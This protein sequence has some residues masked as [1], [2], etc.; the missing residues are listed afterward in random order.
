MDSGVPRGPAMYDGFADM[1]E[2]HAAGSPYNAY[3]DRPAVFDLCGD[4]R[5]RRVLDAG[6]GPGL[7]GEQLIA[8]GA[9]YEGFDVSADMVRVARRRLGE[10]VPLRTHDLERPLS[11]VPDASV[12]LVVCALVVHYLEDRVGALRE[13]R[14]VLAPG[15][16]AVLSTSHPTADWLLDGD[17][18][19][20][21]RH[22]ED[23]W[24]SGLRT[25]WWRQPRQAWFN[26]FTTAGLV[27]ERL[28]EHRPLPA[29]AEHHPEDHARLTRQPGFI[30]YRLC[31]AP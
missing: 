31:P 11:W 5:G 21:A 1:F 12:D 19:F 4:L 26:E 15:G 16:R 30:A 23:T 10:D 20:V 7:Y 8:R 9:R 28:V 24:R 27:V 25:R 3:Y 13:F 22:V 18:Y 2:S 17:G 6:C 29:M 14:R